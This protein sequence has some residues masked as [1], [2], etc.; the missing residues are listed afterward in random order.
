MTEF[1]MSSREHSASILMTLLLALVCDQN[2]KSPKH[3]AVQGTDNNDTGSRM[4]PF[5]M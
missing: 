2:V 1:F 5:F 4:P 3:G